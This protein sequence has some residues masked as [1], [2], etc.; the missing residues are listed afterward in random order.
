MGS[1]KDIEST[2][3]SLQEKLTAM[4]DPIRALLYYE[5]PESRGSSYRSICDSCKELSGSIK[6]FEKSLY[7]QKHAYYFRRVRDWHAYNEVRQR[8]QWQ[9]VA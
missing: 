1:G 4:D 7:G 2:T 9:L 8:T 5:H 6:A 3:N